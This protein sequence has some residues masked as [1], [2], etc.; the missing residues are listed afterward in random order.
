MRFPL[1]VYTLLIELMKFSMQNFDGLLKHMKKT[2]LI[3]HSF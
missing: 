2:H 1:K 3:C